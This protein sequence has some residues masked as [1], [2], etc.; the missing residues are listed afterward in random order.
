MCKQIIAMLAV[1]SVSFSAASL[2][3]AGKIQEAQTVAEEFKTTFNTYHK[4][5][6]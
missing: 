5:Y 1:S 6:R 2:A 3:N 4:K